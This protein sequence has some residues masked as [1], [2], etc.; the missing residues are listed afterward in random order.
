MRIRKLTQAQVA[1]APYE[2]WNAFVDLLF[3]ERYE[4]LSVGQ[5]P[6]QLAI[7]YDG[8]VQNGGHLQY[9]ENKRGEHLDETI[10]ALGRL[11]AF[12]QQKILRGAAALWRSKPRERIETVEEFCDTAVEG[13]FSDFDDHYY[14]CSPSL[15]DLL[16]SHLDKNVS[17]YVLVE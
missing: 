15:T 4:D 11:G 6:A 17:K 12:K 14:N 13:E 5:R 16:Q 1:A 2:V 8:E 9:F 7:Q 3:M 10:V